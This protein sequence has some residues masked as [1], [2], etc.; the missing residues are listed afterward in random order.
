MRI[1][2]D[3]ESDSLQCD[4]RELGLMTPEGFEA[5]SRLWTRVGWQQKY[6][7]RFSWLGRP[8]IQLPEDIVRVQEAICEIRPDLVIETGVAHGGS[9]VLYASVLRALGRGGRVIGIDIEIRPENLRALQEHSLIDD[10]DL[11]VGSSTNPET[12]ARVHELAKGA[13]RVMVLLDSNHSRA[14]VAAE[15]E[16]YADLVTPGSYLIVADGIMKEVSG[17]PLG[18]PEWEH[19]NPIPAID[20]FLA[21]HREYEVVRPPQPFDESEAHW[22]PTYWPDGWL[23]RRES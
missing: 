14:H 8:I 20:D 1:T 12:A 10:I 18:K 4:G 22:D 15:L 11:V 23:R 17:V 21:R 3:T 19:D 9:L 6:S 2:I 7:Y 5:L 16:L 13:Q